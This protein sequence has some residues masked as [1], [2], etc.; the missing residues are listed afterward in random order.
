MCE[1]ARVECEK[2]NVRKIIA[3]MQRYMHMHMHTHKHTYTHIC[4]HI[5]CDCIEDEIRGEDERQK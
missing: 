4:S 5:H 2:M 1:P 3:H